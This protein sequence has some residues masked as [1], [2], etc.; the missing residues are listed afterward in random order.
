MLWS[1]GTALAIVSLTKYS[2]VDVSDRETSSLT[3][4]T[5]EK[6]RHWCPLST[7]PPLD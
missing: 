2:V 6:L 4:R 1:Y 7:H 3:T 5:K